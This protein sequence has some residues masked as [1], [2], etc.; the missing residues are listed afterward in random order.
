MPWTQPLWSPG[1]WRSWAGER[2]GRRGVGVG[3]KDREKGGEPGLLGR[4]TLALPPFR[5]ESLSSP[6]PFTVFMSLPLT[7]CPVSALSCPFTPKVTNHSSLLKPRCHR[8]AL[9]ASLS[10]A[11]SR[12]PLQEVRAAE[13]SELHAELCAA[14]SISPMV[15]GSA[16]EPQGHGEQAPAHFTQH[17]TSVLLSPQPAGPAQDKAPCSSVQA[18]GAVLFGGDRA[19]TGAF[20]SNLLLLRLSVLLT[21][22][23]SLYHLWNVPGGEE[24]GKRCAL[25]KG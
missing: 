11:G 18:P 10:L 20:P 21:P 16:N 5:H 15:Q 7:L 9:K 12:K 2:E 23:L 13:D 4:C 8:H 24:M 19:L 3:A 6:Q 25:W 22:F 17:L 1:Q 14:P